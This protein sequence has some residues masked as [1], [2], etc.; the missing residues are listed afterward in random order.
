[1]VFF[2]VTQGMERAADEAKQRLAGNC[3]SDHL[4]LVKAFKLWEQAQG[5]ERNRIC[6][7]FFMN[8][9]S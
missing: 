1:M 9:V 6:R 3:L 2:A 8:W 7:E 4:M 5:G